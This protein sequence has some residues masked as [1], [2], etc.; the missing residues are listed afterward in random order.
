[1]GIMARRRQKEAKRRK[2]KAAPAAPIHTLADQ[3]ELIEEIME[4][5]HPPK[6][7]RGGKGKE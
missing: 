3:Q 5:N 2:L 1:M 7:H 6:K 4:E